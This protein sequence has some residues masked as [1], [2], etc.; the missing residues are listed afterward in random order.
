MKLSM[1]RHIEGVN[2]DTNKATG[3]ALGVVSH[4]QNPNGI[5]DL[6]LDDFPKGSMY[7]GWQDTVMDTVSVIA[8]IS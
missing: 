5:I 4:G 3:R 8:A 6:E 2:L 1:V 7:R